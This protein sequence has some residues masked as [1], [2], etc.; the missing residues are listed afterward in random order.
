MEFAGAGRGV[1]LIAA[2]LPVPEAQLGAFKGQA[3]ALLTVL[4]GLFLAPLA[5]DVTHSQNQAGIA[6]DLALGA[7]Q[8]VDAGATVA[9][10]QLDFQ[11]VQAAVDRQCIKHALAI[12]E[13]VPDVQVAG[14]TS[15]GFALAP[16]KL[17]LE[18]GVDLDKHAAGTVGDDHGVGRGAKRFGKLVLTRAQGFIVAGGFAGRVKCAHAGVVHWLGSAGVLAGG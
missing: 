11:A 5:G 9:V 13:A 16:A 4:Q 7:I 18:G 14:G 8:Q 15:G 10:V 3:E 17:T 12:G 2:Q 1:D 6:V